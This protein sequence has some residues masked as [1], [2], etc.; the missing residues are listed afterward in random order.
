MKVSDFIADRLLELGNY[1]PR[2]L[3]VSGT[4]GT[5]TVERALAHTRTCLLAGTRLPFLARQ[6]LESPLSDQQLV[7]L[8]REPHYPRSARSVHVEAGSLPGLRCSLSS[9]EQRHDD[10]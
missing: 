3:G 9:T 10:R 4:M 7:A 8:G 5:C 6:G 2:F 1:S